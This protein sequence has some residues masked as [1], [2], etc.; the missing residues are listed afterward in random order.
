MGILAFLIFGNI[1]GGFT[2]VFLQLK[3][4][5][6]IFGSICTAAILSQT[7]NPNPP[8]IVPTRIERSTDLSSIHGNAPETFQTIED[9]NERVLRKV[10]KQVAE[11]DEKSYRNSLQTE[12]LKQKKQNSKTKEGRRQ[13]LCE[14]LGRGC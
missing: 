5:K 7:F 10:A 4:A 12:R 2:S 8:T 14:V 1:V 13:D 11:S 9:D 6:N 3:V